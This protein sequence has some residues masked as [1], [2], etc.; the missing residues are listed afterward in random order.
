MALN[1]FSG[2][3]HMLS[4]VLMPV[5]LLLAKVGSI[6]HEELLTKDFMHSL[7]GQR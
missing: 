3:E 4:S 1:A 5:V 2:N 7:S 6:L